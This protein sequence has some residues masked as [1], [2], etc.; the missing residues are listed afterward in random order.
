MSR[1]AEHLPGKSAVVATSVCFASVSVMNAT[2]KA[3]VDAA[4]QSFVLNRMGGF[5]SCPLPSL[6]YSHT[7]TDSKL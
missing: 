3:D 7:G 1:P 2:N 5:L 4:I 6:N